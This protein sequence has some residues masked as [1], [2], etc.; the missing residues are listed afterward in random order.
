MKQQYKKNV[1]PEENENHVNQIEEATRITTTPDANT[2]NPVTA[3]KIG[4][5]IKDLPTHK[6]QGKFNITNR[7]VKEMG[8]KHKAALKSIANVVVRLRHLPQ[9][10]NTQTTIVR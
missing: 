9:V 4:I 8:R 7:M 5:L 2:H 1:N 10:S 6:S 3:E